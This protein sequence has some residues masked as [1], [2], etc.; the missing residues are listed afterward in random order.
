MVIQARTAPQLVTCL[1]KAPLLTIHALNNAYKEI[2]EY[3]R[4]RKFRNLDVIFE[5]VHYAV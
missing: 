3:K 5:G 4:W 1:F 2:R